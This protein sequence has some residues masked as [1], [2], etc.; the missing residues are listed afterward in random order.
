MKILHVLAQLPEG[1]GSG[2]YFSSMV[3]GFKKYAY[4]QR[5]IFAD[6]DGYNWNVLEKKDQYPVSFKS[7]ELPF[8]IVGMSDVMPYEN[9]RYS[10]MS[11]EMI[12][13]WKEAFK[14]RLVKAREDFQPD[15]IFCHHLWILT[16]LVRQV[17][18]HTKAI[19]ICHNTDLRQAKIDRKSVV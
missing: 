8:P 13:I 15:L 16:S 11:E 17:F 7:G 3:E 1:T 5:A 10:S 6:Q 18:P 4:E 12:Y 14:K 19:G 2:V 9:T